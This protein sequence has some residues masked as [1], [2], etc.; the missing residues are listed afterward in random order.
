MTS[1]FA[2]AAQ[3]AAGTAQSA[4]QSNPLPFNGD[5]PFASP[6]DFKGGAFT[7]TPSMEALQGRTC[8]FI[9]RT[10]NPAAADPF[11]PG[12]TRKQW[13]ADLYVLDGGELRFWYKQK[14]DLSAV[15]PRQE[16]QVEHIVPEVTPATP[17]EVPQMWVSQAAIV[18]KLTGV[19]EKRQFLVCTIVRGAQKAQ[20]DKGATDASVRAEHDAWV[21]RGKAG[22]EPKSLWLAEDLSAEQMGRV[23]E[24]WAGAKDTVKL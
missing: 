3:A 17:F 18:P 24:W 23:R 2:A 1:A 11:N 15:P 19:S 9:P 6:S 14:A 10:F 12:Q 8:V 21:A 22:P 13:T 16:A 7:P 4:P 20:R 5:D